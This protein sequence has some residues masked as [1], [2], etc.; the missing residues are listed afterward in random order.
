MTDSVGG[1]RVA[2]LSEALGFAETVIEVGHSH[3]GVRRAL[4]AAGGTAS[5]LVSLD[6]ERIS[7]LEVEIG[8]G[9]RGFE[10]EVESV[11]RERRAL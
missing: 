11:L 2:T 10:K 7:D 1:T 6:D 9:H 8:I 4:S 5:F 3:P